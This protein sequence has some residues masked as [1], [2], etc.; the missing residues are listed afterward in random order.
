[1]KVVSTVAALTASTATSISILKCKPQ[2]INIT[3]NTYV[4]FSL[5]KVVNVEN[6]EKK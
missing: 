4:E 2:E 3:K 5:V 6:N 1:M